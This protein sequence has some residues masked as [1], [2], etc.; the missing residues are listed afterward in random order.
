MKIGNRGRILEILGC[1]QRAVL[2]EKRR[3]M[4]VFFVAILFVGLI[5]GTA[6]AISF[7]T[8]P[9]YG[10]GT[11]PQS[12]AI[13][14]FNGDGNPDL[15]VA[16]NSSNNV[17]VLLGNGDGTF[18]TRVDYAA[19][20]GPQSIVTGDFNGDGKLDLAIANNGA[21]NVSVLLGYGDGT[22][23]T[24]V[25]YTVG[26]APSSVAVGDFN[27]DGKID[28]AVANRSTNNISVL[29]GNGDG[30][31]R[32]A[33]NYAAATSPASVTTGDF[34]GDGK[35]DLAVANTGS[36]NISV[37]LGNGDGTFATA[38]NYTSGLSPFSI[39]IGD[40]N[41]DGK[42][43]TAVANYS[44]NTNT[45]S[46][47][48][49]NGDGTFQA[50]VDYA[51]GTNPTSVTT[52]DFNADG[53]IDL[54][55]SSYSSYDVTVLLGNGDG[56]FRAGVSY[57]AG[58]AA[59]SV[60]VGDFNGDGNL[61]LVTAN[62]TGS[63]VSV[64]LGN[65]DGTFQGSVNCIVG[66]GPISVTTGDFNRD[67]VPDLAVVNNQSNTISVLVASGTGTF[68]T[69]RTYAVGSYAQNVVSGDFNRD[70]KLDLVVP[71]NGN[72]NVSVLLSNGDGTFQNAVNSA[73]GTSPLYVAAGDFNGDSILD[74][75]IANGTS[76]VV[77]VLL[78][79]GNGTF[80]GAVSYAVTYPKFVAVGDFNGDGKLDLVTANYMNNNVSVLLGNGNGTF[81]GAVNYATGT[82]PRSVAIG[83][84]NGDGK[85]DLAV[86]NNTSHNVSV[87]Q[88]NG[89]GTFQAAVNYAVGYAPYSVITGDFN[90]DGILDLATANNTS[91]DVSILLGNGNGTFQSKVSFA[92]GKAPYAVTAGD[93]NGDGKVDLA[94]ANNGSDRVTV[95][96]NTMLRI[97]PSSGA[98][99]TISCNP[100]MVDPKGSSTCSITPDSG[101]MVNDV[102]V[103]GSSVG[104]V[105]SYNITNITID[106]TITAT[107]VAQAWQLSVS[108]VGSGTVTSS[109]AGIDCGNTCTASYN[110][111]TL[112]SLSA[113]P[114]T[115]Y[116]FSGWSGAC[117]GSGACS[118][119]MS[120]ARS[121]TATFAALPSCSAPSSI[122]GPA[123]SSTGSY[124][125]S[126]GSSATTGSSYVVEESVNSGPWG[127][128]STGTATS[129]DFI[130]KTNGTYQYRV[131]ATKAGY[132]ESGWTSSGVVIVDL[133]SPLTTATPPGGTYTST[134]TVTLSCNDGAGSGCSDINYCLGAGC[135]PVTPY[136]TQLDISSSSVLRFSS[137]DNVGN[138]ESVKTETYSITISTDPP[139]NAPYQITAPANAGSGSYTVN[140]FASA[141]IGAIYVLEEKVGSG[142]WAQVYTGTA[143][144]YNVSSKTNGT[145]QY[146][147][148]AIAGGYADSNWST[149]GVVTVALTCSAPY[150][151]TVP[152]NSASGSYAINWYAS[153]TIGASYVLEESVNSGAYV[154]VYAGTAASFTISNKANGTY[155]Y[156]V[157]A[158]AGGYTDSLWTTS[159]IVTV[160]LTCSAPYQITAPANSATGSYVISWYASAT[161]GAVYV[162]EE[163][164]NSGAYV[165]MYSGTAA[166]FNF[167]SKAN[168]TYQYR[169][170]AILAGSADSPWT[171]SGIV[172]VAITCMAPYQV[173]APA[174]STTGNYAISWYPSA[175][176]GGTYVLE[177][178][179]NSG[180]FVQV[181]TGTATSYNFS[182]KANGTYQYRVK[183]TKSGST[184][185]SW[186]LSRILTVQLT[187][188]A[189]Y[190]I[191]IFT[192]TIPGTYL[193]SWTSS[194]T[195]GVTYVLEEQKNGGAWTETT[196]TMTTNVNFSG[197]T[198]GTYSYRVRATRS[199]YQD[200]TR[201][202]SS[203]STII[204]P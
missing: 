105:G 137:R 23:R 55:V 4:A 85:P 71:N 100:T 11:G 115:N 139:C 50:K 72:N 158:I 7:H 66:T 112:V 176:S 192:S 204:V 166:S 145:Y 190:S 44:V 82:Y 109:P 87:L 70:G 183:V 34:N 95:L 148:K 68:Q 168:G 63:N 178:K 103:N 165:Q 154:Q 180:A 185:S 123:T 19:G 48:L 198:S 199:G 52:G 35:A 36:N 45:V 28:L 200:S 132:V 196:T 60:T 24:A 189:P 159:G 117:T 193:V 75:V 187:C 40:F 125:I 78:G 164:A 25:N 174:S 169:V 113:S 122:T 173:T 5:A 57:S 167:S 157:K 124:A 31:F 38:V 64:F 104:A 59:Q 80:Q 119:T 8:V 30:T 151:I 179:V 150:Q 130:G 195:S 197:K 29:L 94:V 170:K 90:R 76:N 17:S 49:G 96:L 1:Q 91:N 202:S 27:G 69:A 53:H 39:T 33:V 9:T 65:G 47:F 93:F 97:A 175:T 147:V 138:A 188:A 143:M 88:G 2:Y 191:F 153:A 21:N 26:T 160:A 118:V 142:A 108:L 149:S 116:T 120:Q 141:T 79:N 43:D 16:N 73:A 181:Y 77:S 152:A 84:Y 111:G 3:T 162:L 10:A 127:I 126:W 41:G 135:S 61:D 128:V 22:F 20:T 184:D 98:H 42:P 171:T 110:E 177:E 182:N 51:V 161:T 155:Q 13:G 140:W 172:T 86:A 134:Q 203:L 156:R 12:V 194:A 102:T 37:F 107:F 101:Y 18:R 136:T 89:D 92:V 133:N 106:Q 81:Q 201:T 144:S 131:K 163:S 58:Q 99:G 146:R 6:H 83:D 114:A 54:V 15:A 46:V 62:S 56:S 74:L 14:D 67:G 32:T 121:V 129:V 186:K